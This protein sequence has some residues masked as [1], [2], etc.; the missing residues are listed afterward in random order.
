MEKWIYFGGRKH[1]QHQ[2]TSYLGLTSL[3]KKKSTK[4]AFQQT[5]QTLC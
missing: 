2:K 5:S 1:E 4:T 3:K